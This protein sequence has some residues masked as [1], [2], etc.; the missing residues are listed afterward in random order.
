MIGFSRFDAASDTLTSDKTPKKNEFLASRWQKWRSE[1]HSLCYDF[2]VHRGTNRERLV[3]S[4]QRKP[5]VDALVNYGLNEYEAK[6]YLT[7]LQFGTSVAG[8]LARRSGIPRPRIYDTLQRLIDGSLVSE[9]E[10][11]P[12]SYI[13]LPLDDFL[14]RQEAELRRRQDLLRAGLK[15]QRSETMTPGLFHILDD[16]K[17]Y[18]VIEDLIEAAERRLHLQLSGPDLDQVSAALERNVARGVSV[19]GT[20]F[21]SYCPIQGGHLE[22]RP[23]AE[24]RTSGGGRRF[25]VCRDVEEILVGHIG[26]SGRSYAVGTRNKLLVEELTR[27]GQG[28]PLTRAEAKLSPLL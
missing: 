9:I 8:D 26:G 1:T 2:A 11:S 7:L 3:D 13:P 19:S 25:L 28:S 24:G 14:R 5:L 10:G 16:A 27:N 20:F 4:N 6:A 21:G 23:A 12:R 22:T 18:R 17:I 15:P